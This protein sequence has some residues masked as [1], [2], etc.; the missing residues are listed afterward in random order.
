MNSMKTPITKKRKQTTSDGNKKAKK[1]EM[2][3]E[4]EAVLRKTLKVKR[5]EK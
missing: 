3:K 2:R 5:K 4:K 1:D